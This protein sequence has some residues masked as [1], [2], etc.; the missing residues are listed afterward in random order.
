MRRFLHALF[1][2]GMVSALGALMVSPAHAATPRICVNPHV[3]GKGDTGWVCN[4]NGQFFYAGTVGENRALEGVT[5]N[6]TG[7]GGGYCADA[8]AR[9][10]G[11]IGGADPK[12]DQCVGEGE[13]L[14]VGTRGQNRP[15]EALRLR[16]LSSQ[17]VKG[18][19]HMQNT[20]WGGWAEGRYIEIGSTGEAKNLE[21][22]VFTPKASM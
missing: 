11:W 10:W 21:A 4:Q 1:T 7:M 2:L 9:N 17:Y 5:I 3:A 15:L 8:H 18:S 19:A 6:I 13:N 14:F 22:V 12:N 20:G 16:M